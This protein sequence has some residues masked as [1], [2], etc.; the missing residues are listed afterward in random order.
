[1]K[2]RS[3]VRK[4]WMLTPALK[5]K[6]EDLHAALDSYD[7]ENGDRYIKECFSLGRKIDRLLHPA[8]TAAT[9]AG[10]EAVR[11]LLKQLPTGHYHRELSAWLERN[12]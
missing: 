12:G 8:I 6:I 5:A 9:H 3:S 11:D 2:K 1:M 4:P 10:P 7:N